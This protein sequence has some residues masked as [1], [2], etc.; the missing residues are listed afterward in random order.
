MVDKSILDRGRSSI[1]VGGTS[2]DYSKPHV[3]ARILKESD[4][5]E[6]GEIRRDII[7]NK[8]NPS[9]PNEFL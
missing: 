2:S 7:R 5:S 3:G 8:N 1:E 6:G 4:F 9:G